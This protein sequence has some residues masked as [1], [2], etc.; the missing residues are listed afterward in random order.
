MIFSSV[1]AAVILFSL[2]IVFPLPVGT[3]FFLLFECIPRFSTF[4]S[5]VSLITVPNVETPALASPLRPSAGA[6]TALGMAWKDHAGVFWQIQST[7]TP[8]VILLIV[9]VPG[10]AGSVAGVT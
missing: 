6:F 7:T 4:A 10:S 2:V 9:A 5:G 3:G 1:S 8:Y